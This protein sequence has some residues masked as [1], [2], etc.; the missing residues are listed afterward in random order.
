M[1]IVYQALQFILSIS[2][3]VLIHEL[4]HFMFARI[5]K[6]KV[7]K[8]YLFFNP[9]FSLFK[10]TSKKTGTEYGLGW[11]P[12]G[13]YCSIAGMV[14]ET[15]KADQLAAEPQEWEYRSKPAWQ[16]LLVIVGG[17]LFNTIGAFVI[18]SAMLGFWGKEYIPA[19]NA[20]YGYQFSEVAKEIGFKNGDKILDVDGKPVKTLSDISH[21]ILLEKAAYAKV[22]RGDSSLTVYIPADFTQ[23]LL[24]SNTS[25][26][27]VERFPFVIENVQKGMAAEKAG[28]Q[29]GDS[30][31]SIDNVPIGIFQDFVEVS[32]KFAGKTAEVCYKRAG[33][34]R[35]GS[36]HIDSNGKL[37]VYT[38]PFDF[39]KTEKETYSVLAAIPAG[40][41]MGYSTLTNYVKQLKIV[42]TKE[43]AKNLGGFG[44]MASLYEKTWDWRSFWRTTALLSIILAVMNIL[45]IPALDGGHLL[46][47]L[48]EMITGKK[49]NDKFLEYA[50]MVGFS[51][52]I[53]LLLYAN[54]NDILRYFFK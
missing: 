17:V 40:I 51:L 28:L 43:G 32:K 24:A 46:F 52:L 20:V 50:Q 4:G 47:I 1:S 39:I 34:I 12:L 37:G 14:D 41:K 10:Y 45:P 6:I 35:T 3:L 19:K 25:V 38:N 33:Q 15:K 11:L 2:L 29:K 48:F 18:Y 21:M 22:Q 30:L 42:F 8:F 9:W 31:I 13:G 16:R 26:L 53:L 5:F 49:P 54:G 23:R 7:E 44:T 27:M 36:L